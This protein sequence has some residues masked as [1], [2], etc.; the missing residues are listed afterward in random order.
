ME[1]IFIGYYNAVDDD[2]FY[3][4]A[5]G[6]AGTGGIKFS[7]ESIEK[8]RNSHLGQSRPMSEEQK[9]KLSE[10]ARN[11]SEEVRKKYSDARKKYI[12]EHG[13]TGFGKKSVVQIDKDTLETIAIYDSET[14]AG[15]AIGHEYTHIAQVCRGE[16]K[17]AYGYIWR[18]ADELEE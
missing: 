13:C 7:A 9:K 15:K 3:N 8:M 14:A 2:Q 17:T 10:I 16:R 4:I 11:R 6:G 18:F 5:K 1:E 12:A